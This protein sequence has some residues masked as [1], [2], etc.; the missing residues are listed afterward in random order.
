MQLPKQTIK[1]LKAFHY[2]P[3]YNSYEL[4]GAH[5]TE[6]DGEKGVLFIVW[7]PNANRVHLVGDFN[8]WNDEADPMEKVTDTGIWGIFFKGITSGEVYKYKL[9]LPDGREV[10][11]ADPYAFYS[12]VRPETSS[13]TYNLDQYEWSDQDWMSNRQSFEPF[14]QPINIYEIHLGSWKL[15]E[16]GKLDNEIFKSVDPTAFYSYREIADELIPYLKEMHYNYLEILPVMEHPFDGSWGYQV[17]GF[18]SITSRYGTPED[19]MY[20]IDKCHQAGIGVIIDWVPGHFCRDEHGLM[21]FDGTELYG[22]VDHPNWG[23]KK[24]DFSKSEVRNFLISNA[25]FFFEKFHID[26][27][28]VDGVTSILQLNFGMDGAPYRNEDGGTED[29]W[30]VKFLR[31]LNKEIFKKYPYALMMAEESTSWPMVTAPIDEGG[32][33]FN[34]KWKMGW[35]NDTLD[36]IELDPLFRKGSH[37]KITFSMHYSYSENFLLPFS[38]D[39][40]VHGKKSL[41][42]KIPAEYEDKFKNLKL[43][44]LYQMTHPGKK[45]NF[46][47]NEIGQFIEWRY[48]EPVEWFL[49]DYP[50]HR[51]HQQ[52]N[53]EL[54][55]LYLQEKSL[56]TKDHD[57]DGF[58]WIDADNR[59]QSIYIYERKHDEDDSV[60][61]L[62]NFTPVEY[63]AFRIGVDEGM[64]RVMFTT[65]EVPYRMKTY[66][67]IQSEPIPSHGY[68]D[69]ITVPIPGLTGLILKKRKTRKK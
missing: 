60:I 52:F 50:I 9:S 68:Q 42:D 16:T 15:K 48:Y 14:D 20:L 23:T 4:F 35:M 26:G 37:E 61:I 18:Y 12:E 43:L 21:L 57:P 28:R 6:M 29:L 11:K 62:L 5:E 46:M 1:Q 19:F 63:D 47:G 64:Y 69:S 40:V 58:K 7:A 59:D 65:D 17:T 13:V 51:A 44:M 45:L 22:D 38:H 56:Y 34:Y 25:S 31:E 66:R 33:G 36:Y 55:K 10:Y 27:I 3:T 8:Y 32:L 54:N 49:L 67:Y 24:F 53:Q 39:E 30:G 41:I 2:E